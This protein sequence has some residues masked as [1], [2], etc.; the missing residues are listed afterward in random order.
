MSAMSTNEKVGFLSSRAH[1][2]L[3]FDRGWCESVCKQIN[4]KRGRLPGQARPEGKGGGEHTENMKI[5]D[6]LGKY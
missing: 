2:I 3:C 6:G 1:L 5:G 4:E